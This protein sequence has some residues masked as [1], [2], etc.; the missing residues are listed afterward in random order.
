MAAVVHVNLA[1]IFGAETWKGLPILVV[2]FMEGGTLS[3]RLETSA[4]DIG[5]TLELGISLTEVLEKIH[6]AG[7]LHRDIKPS[8]IGYTQDGIP[9][10]MDFGVA[11][12]LAQPLKPQRRSHGDDALIDPSASLALTLPEQTREEGIYGT[13]RYMAPEALNASEPS[14][15][16]DIWSLNVVLFECLTQH[17][18]FGTTNL[19]ELTRQRYQLPRLRDY[20]PSVSPDL[21]NFFYQVFSPNPEKRPRTAKDLRQTLEELLATSVV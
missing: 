20:M 1:M 9:K 3:D 19:A 12:M 17:N 7:I 6:A 2:E 4:L 21:E 16:F 18:P 15:D 10:L 5:K 11:R 14:P 13:P 8:N